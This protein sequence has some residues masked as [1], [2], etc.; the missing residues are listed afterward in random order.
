[1]PLCS[2][3][4]QFPFSA[5]VA[6]KS[7]A[8]SSVLLS[9]RFQQFMFCFVVGLILLNMAHASALGLFPHKQNINATIADCNIICLRFEDQSQKKKGANTVLSTL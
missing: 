8:T 1:M 3:H 2:P 6:G 7:V 9:I 4:H 5:A